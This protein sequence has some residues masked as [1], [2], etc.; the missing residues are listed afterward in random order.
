MKDG[1]NVWNFGGKK[2]RRNN[3]RQSCAVRL[4]AFR[5]ALDCFPQDVA[6]LCAFPKFIVRRAFQPDALS[7][8]AGRAK[9]ANQQRETKNDRN[10]SI[11]GSAADLRNTIRTL[12]F[13]M[14]KKTS[15]CGLPS[16][17][18]G[19]TTFAMALAVSGMISAQDWVDVT[20]TYIENADY[21]TG[22]TEGWEDGT[23]LPGVNATFQNAELYQSLNSASQRIVGLKAGRYKLAVQ[24]FHRG[25]RNDAGA[26]YEAGTETIYAYL[27]ART[28]SV[29]MKSLY[30][31]PKD[32]GLPN[33]LNGWPDGMEGMHAYCEAYPDRYWNEVEFTAQEGQSLLLGVAINTRSTGTWTCWD[34]FKL[35]IEG[36]SFDAFAVKVSKLQALT[37]SLARLGVASSAELSSV[38]EKYAAYD[39]STPEGDIE[40]ASVELEERTVQAQD[41]CAQATIMQ[42]SI[43]K[44]ADLYDKM[45][46]GDYNVPAAVEQALAGAMEDA[47]AVMALPALAD[48]EAA[49]ADGISAMDAATAQ[50][51]SY[52][53]LSYTLQKAKELA[54][55]V[56]GLS[57]VEAYR[58]V[59]ALLA[60]TVELTYDEAALATAALNAECASA[61]SPELLASAS[62]ENPIELTSFI[63]NPNVYQGVSELVAPAGWDCYKG[64]ADG[65][66]YTS[67]EGTGNCDLI[68]D[69]WTGSR[70]TGSRYG[71]RIGGEEECAVRLPDGLYT[72]KAATYTNAGAANV[73][74]YASTDSVD[75]AFAE[76]N[77]DLDLYT[78][79]GQ[80][81][82][83][84]TEVSNFEVRGGRLHLGVVCDGP[85][86][87]NGREWRADNFRLYYVKS[88]VI[89]AYR[90]RLQARLDSAAANHAKFVEWGIDDSDTYGYA[91]EDYPE[92]I[93]TG[94][95]EELEMGIAELETFN[96]EAD[97]IIKHYETLTSL[98]SEGV[99]LNSQ[100]AEEVVVAQ[101]KA[102]DDFSAALEDAAV[103]AEDM[104]WD[105]YADEAIDEKIVALDQSMKNL[106]ASVALCF[107]MAKAKVLADQIGGLEQTEAY[108]AVDAL[109]KSDEMD[110]VDADMATETL[111]MVCVEALT[112]EVLT[113]ASVDDPLDMTSFILNPNIYQDSEDVN[114]LPVNTLVNGWECTTTAD[115]PART[116][117][118]SGDTWLSC[119]SW[120]G[121]AAH[122]IG[123]PA[124]YSQVLGNLGGQEGKVALP[125]G[126]YRV[127][128]ATYCTRQSELIQLFALTRQV[129]VEHVQGT[130]MADSL[131]Y[132]FTDSV[133][134]DAPFNADAD[135]WE[136]AQ[137]TLSTTTVI[138]EVYVENGTLVIGVRGTGVVGGNGQYWWADNFRL[139][140]VGTDKGDDIRNISL[141]KPAECDEVD[142]F[143]L[144]GRKVRQ[145]V[146]RRNALEGLHKGIYIM[147]GKKYLVK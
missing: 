125:D 106:K 83:T 111:K 130:T 119:W 39:A 62:D 129:E 53:S 104:S 30:S 136:A 114:G 77:E 33:N 7:L 27:F 10:R 76:A 131:V 14:R 71:Q 96:A 23:A 22:T 90:D 75:F 19:V 133:F 121:N 85:V 15:L 61:M 4:I 123:T 67:P 140:Y 95:L 108:Q 48:V 2:F 127:E 44:A 145:A 138:P 113:Q 72:L 98:L 45:K 47:R 124:V 142:V 54:D 116:D 34:N 107:P 101:P 5:K 128:A 64:S 1:R 74:L 68:C 73:H 12:D 147:D 88:N 51:A 50:A 8:E 32:A 41:L 120:S 66:W 91:L 92:I 24:G 80:A 144:A 109:L 21:A 16:V 89:S 65:T 6:R 87:G 115:S 17:K 105:N 84:T 42:A 112:P 46:A 13:I 35:Y 59:E 52:V 25:G 11:K 70:L 135:A 137:G 79:A 132:T 103:Y 81:M 43:S 20:D 97:S 55:R 99:N 82:T 100:L 102:K 78:Q 93:A 69:S 29:Q 63:A 60:G 122:N 118:L 26:G 40:S 37:D 28:D 117:G 9:T 126:A 18:R 94:T 146:S 49:I 31:E 58:Q 139:Y 36:S 110:Q 38:V 143:D 3:R 56:G 57:D 141:D 86:S 134:V